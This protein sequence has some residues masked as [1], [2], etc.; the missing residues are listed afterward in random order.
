L[1]HTPLHALHVALDAKMAPFAGYDMP[2][3]YAAG[4]LGEHQ[5][6]RARASLFDVSHMGQARL[7]GADALA[8]LERLVPGDI[9][10]LAPGR[11]RYSLLTS[12]AGGILDDLMIT[13]MGDHL[14][15]VYNAARKDTDERHITAHLPAGCTL[16]VMA[17]QALIALQGPAAAA[18]L[19]RHA[20]GAPALSFMSAATMDVAG[21]PAIVSRSG[22]TGEDGYE[23]S[24]PAAAA[25]EVARALLDEP[26]VAPAG[27]GARDSLRLEAGLCL[28]GADIDETTSPI[29]AGL[30]WTIGKRRKIEGGFL[31]AEP[32][33]AQLFDGPARRRVGI[34]PDGRAPARAHTPIL[35]A[36]DAPI[37]E[38]TSG[39][40]SPTLGRPIAMGYVATDFATDGTPV[41]LEIRGRVHPGHIAP[42]PFVPHHYKR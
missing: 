27:L 18:A 28:Y 7:Y 2:L 15:L 29:E 3:H 38:V 10:A 11:M 34:L 25:Q 8:A 21:A 42:M 13:R 37:G 40:F 1:R 22:Y 35:D 17:D 6:T 41:G 23:I 20:P 24:L 9:Q 30:A 26:E 12:P 4:I 14:Y 32:I 33:M 31:G 5:H 36:D 16:E 39:G 19:G